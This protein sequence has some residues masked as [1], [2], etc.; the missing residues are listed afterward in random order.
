MGTVETESG[1]ALNE[2]IDLL[3]EVDVRCL[4]TEW[5]VEVPEDVSEGHRNLMHLLA[6]G[7]VSHLEADPERPRFQRIVT[8][9]RKLMGDNPDAI[10]FE[11]PVRPDR[12][13]RVRGNTAGAV[14]M[15]ITVESGA[16]EGRFGTATGGWINDT[17]LDIADDGSFELLVGGDRP[18]GT[19]S[20]LPLPEDAGM[21]T[22]RHYFE[23]QAPVAA[24]PLRHI[25]LTI[26]PLEPPG[27][28]PRPSDASIAAGIR[29]VVT[30]V[31]SRTLGLLPPSER[32]RRP[33]VSMI[34][35]TFP[36]PCL[37][38]DY[39]LTAAD[40]AYSL[41]PYVIAPD[42]ALVVT[43]RFPTCRFANI[44]LW[45]RYIQT[46]D[47][48]YRRTS[49]NRAQTTLEPDGSFRIVLAH[50]DPGV[51]NWLDTE[52]RTFGI[53]FWR[54]MMPEGEIETP[55]ARVVGFDELVR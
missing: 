28:P 6:S 1:K 12:A 34:P 48:V 46:Y 55:E 45:N 19:R 39:A 24:D 23:E 53:A 14:Y 8:P 41:A 20:W 40:A 29:R 47:Y 16:Q 17:G 42:E 31:R 25:P 36:A 4:G 33:F 27:P 11:A 26:E 52:G 50:R 15:S 10:Y 22:T 43:G 7:L 21:L 18:E 13:Y 37:P 2:L 35:N 54:F 5:N 32:P 44:V 30:S 3:H 38:G 9:T 51:P 49:L